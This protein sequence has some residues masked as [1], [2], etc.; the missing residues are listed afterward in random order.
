MHYVEPIRD[1]KTIRN[2]LVYLKR[3]NER[4]YIMFLLGIHTGLRISDILRLRVRDVKNRNH[5]SIIEMKTKKPKKF[6]INAE[7]KREL[8][9]YCK[10]KE[11]YEY[12]ISSREGGNNPI[13]R[14]RAYQILMETGY[15]FDIHISCHVLRK[16]FGYWHYM[17]NKDVV[18]L[19][20]IFNHSDQRVT[21]RYIGII[22]DELDK[23]V[24]DITFL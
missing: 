5:I 16:T 20:E 10:G 19:M 24:K 22:Q 12:L 2:I 21:L 23:S 3:E 8:N 18:K 6:L 4:N 15:L 11:H 17:Q 13:N 9:N 14:V 7:L 1:K